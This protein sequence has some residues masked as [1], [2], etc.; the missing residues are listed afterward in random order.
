MVD[1][2]ECPESIRTINAI[3]NNSGTAEVKLEHNGKELVVVETA[4]QV[5]SKE[6]IKK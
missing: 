2:K 5:K 3:I 1:I 4:R 6:R